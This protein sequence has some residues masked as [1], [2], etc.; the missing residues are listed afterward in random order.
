MAVGDDAVAAGMSLV[1]DTGEEGLIK[2]GA[3]E[4]NRT[5]DYVAQTLGL[6]PSNYRD[7]LH[8]SYGTGDPTGG[9][10]GDIYFKVSS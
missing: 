6:I 7:A 8:I 10:D 5:R 1:P 2:H 4:I 3:R 9:V